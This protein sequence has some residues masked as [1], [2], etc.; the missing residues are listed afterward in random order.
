MTKERSLSTCDLRVLEFMQNKG[1]ITTKQAI[2]H[3]GETRLSARIYNIR[4]Y[5]YFVAGEFIE[6]L[7]RRGEKR[8][9]KKYFIVKTSEIA[10]KLEKAV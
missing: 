2:D 8:R 6:V 7:N 4:K 1:S 9:I 5:G 10:N 3:L